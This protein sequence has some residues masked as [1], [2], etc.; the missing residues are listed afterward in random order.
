[1]REGASRLSSGGVTLLEEIDAL[2][3][4]ILAMEAEDGLPAPA[5]GA[6]A[7]SPRRALR[8]RVAANIFFY[9]ALLLALLLTAS[10]VLNRTAAGGIGGL[11]FFIEQTNAAQPLFSR[12]ALLITVN[13]PAAEIKKGDVIRYYAVEGNADSCLTRVV[14]ER[15]ENYNQGGMTFFRTV[16]PAQGAK[17]DSIAVNET[18]IAGV[19]LAAIPFAGYVISALGEYAAGFAAL[20]VAL[21]CA[22][23]FLRKM[24]LAARSSRS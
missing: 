20:A 18:N 5:F 2:T 21:C 3:N 7:Y 15:L 23:V 13:R 10:L 9:A 14:A 8:L 17:P 6:V 11:R 24:R 19:K 22:A 16:R 1:L 4:E 12:G